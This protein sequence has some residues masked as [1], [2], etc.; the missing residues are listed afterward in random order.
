MI[1]DAPPAMYAL[2]GFITAANPLVVQFTNG[3]RRCHPLLCVAD[4]SCNVRCWS[5][6]VIEAE[7]VQKPAPLHLTQASRATSV[8]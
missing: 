3:G 8:P 5:V 2:P 4:V 7:V 1:Q 6:E